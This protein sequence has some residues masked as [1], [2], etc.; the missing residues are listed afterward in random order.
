MFVGLL[1]DRFMSSLVNDLNESDGVAVLYSDKK[2][3][4]KLSLSGTN[5]A[6]ES[7]P[8]PFPSGAHVALA[9]ERPFRVCEATAEDGR[10]E[11]PPALG[12]F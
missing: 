9:R 11:L 6:R 1:S 7:L 5:G 8:P 4:F 2:N 12:T 3:R 10:I